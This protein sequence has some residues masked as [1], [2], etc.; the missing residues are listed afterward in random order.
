MKKRLAAVLILGGFAVG[1]AAKISQA[2]K[3]LGA[4]GND[5]VGR[6]QLFFSPLARADAYLVDTETGRIWRPVTISNATDTNLKSTAPEV[7]LYQDRIDNAQEFEGWAAYH[8]N[9]YPGT[10]PH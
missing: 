7:W 5:R 1:Q 2:P 4:N 3:P 9:A 10:G 8:N 6:Y